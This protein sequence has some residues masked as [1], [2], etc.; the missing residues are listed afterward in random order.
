M[1]S[2]RLYEKWRN[3]LYD[4]LTKAGF[5]C[6]MPEGAYY[7]LADMPEGTGMDDMAFARYM[8][9]EVGVAAVPGSS[10]YHSEPGKHKLHFMFSKKDETLQQ[11]IFMFLSLSLALP[12]YPYRSS[13]PQ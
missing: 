5:R 2:H 12:F 1:L 3:F 8:I 10:F 13:H 7:I 11:A 9:N 6:N 4:T